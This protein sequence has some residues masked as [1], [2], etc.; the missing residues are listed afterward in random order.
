MSSSHDSP[1]VLEN[2]T[3]ECLE[4]ERAQ[5]VFHGRHHCGMAGIVLMEQVAHES[6]FQRLA[7]AEHCGSEKGGRSDKNSGS[8]EIPAAC[9]Y[10]D[11]TKDK[12]ITEENGE[13]LAMDIVC[14]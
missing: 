14:P 3:R 12:E 9:C 6:P 10:S 11:G 7:N 4:V 13:N 2:F 5:H 8:N 1:H